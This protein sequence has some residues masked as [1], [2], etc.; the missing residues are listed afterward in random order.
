[1][2]DEMETDQPLQDP[3]NH[4]EVEPL[5]HEETEQYVGAP[6]SAENGLE[7]PVIQS[8]DESTRPPFIY[9]VTGRT[10]AERTVPRYKPYK[11]VAD[12]ADGGHASARTR[13]SQQPML[14][15]RTV[16]TDQVPIQSPPFAAQPT[17]MPQQP[18]YFAA[19]PINPS[20]LLP[21]ASQPVIEPSSQDLNTITQP[22][23][24]PLVSQHERSATVVA[25]DFPKVVQTSQ[26]TSLGGSNK[27]QRHDRVATPQPTE[28][29]MSPTPIIRAQVLNN[30][31]R[32]LSIHEA[33][34][35]LAAP[36]PAVALS[37]L[38]ASNARLN[39]PPSHSAPTMG[40]ISAPLR[41]SPKATTPLSVVR[42]VPSPIGSINSSLR[43]LL[44]STPDRDLGSTGAH[45]SRPQTIDPN[46][47][48]LMTSSPAG[49]HTIP[50][51]TQHVKS[52][53]PPIH[54]LPPA[55]VLNQGAEWVPI[56]PSIGPSNQNAEEE[57]TEDE[58]EM[59]SS[60]YED[61]ND[62]RWQKLYGMIRQMATTQTSLVLDV[63]RLNSHVNDP[64][65]RSEH[66][67]Q[68]A[69][70]TYV[71]PPEPPKP[72]NWDQSVVCDTPAGRRARARR[73]IFVAGLIR[74]ALG[75]MLKRI[76][77]KEPLPDPPPA[78][79][80]APSEE[81]FGI[82]YNETERS[83]FNQMAA[84]IVA[85]KIV[86]DQPDL[87]TA[88]EKLELRTK[89]T[90]HLKYLCRRYKDENRPDAEEFNRRRL[91]RCSAGSRKRQ[92]YE[93]R[94]QTLD[95]F[96]AALGKHRRLIVHLGVD[97]TSSDEEDH[98]NPGMYKIKAKPELSTKVTQLKRNLDFVYNLYFK[99]P[100]SKGS[101]VHRRVPSHLVSTRPF[102]IEQLPVTCVSRT[103][104]QSLDI[105]EREFF[106]F[107]PHRY[108]YS[109]PASLY[110]FRPT[111]EE[112]EVV[113]DSSPA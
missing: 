95:R 106:R 63:Q 36:R 43:S 62:A 101:Q 22:V 110:N 53:T 50:P 82:R 3:G 40:Q 60:V 64:S 54:T 12:A 102:T 10:P 34:K 44:Y 28:V 27:R 77:N 17:Y 25:T 70:G 9:H 92:L 75:S 47:P 87:L 7:V 98:R 94:L 37:T 52:T 66:N 61:N 73:E 85:E 30:T 31:D 93:T 18:T 41:S 78:S 96:P 35:N 107:R 39:S 8:Q 14:N 42:K 84:G 45:A 86:R 88:V 26:T 56:L 21:V 13:S 83:P 68:G 113:R 38:G 108:D 19:H 11:R 111:N 57:A 90:K 65:K 76:S 32:A 109:F 69:G 103:W 15:A 58:E 89:V 2:S 72:V 46:S 33:T 91:K 79:L 104:F 97:G 16:A 1:M 48:P 51:I 6:V 99:G 24:V 55:V 49:I 23:A 100:G 74:G 5:G 29:R 4:I 81:E 71:S 67:G 112:R 59:I 80:R 105:A 20:H